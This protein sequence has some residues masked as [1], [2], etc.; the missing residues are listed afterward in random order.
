VIGYWKGI[1]TSEKQTFAFKVGLTSSKSAASRT[2]NATAMNS[3]VETGWDKSVSGGATAG[4]FGSG[5]NVQGSSADN[6][7]KSE[8]ASVQA[9]LAREI[10]NLAGESSEM[11]HETTCTP[12]DG[13]SGAG[14]W[15]WVLAT[16]DY[17]TS[18]FTSHTLCRTGEL[19]RTP[20]SCSFDECDDAQCT[21]CKSYKKFKTVD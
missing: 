3:A 12:G 21:V 5:V 18:A 1:T 19:A 8:G 16:S 6:G 11:S 17:S 15:Q 14:L 7:K 20:P 2:E 10:N 4:L 9:S 13:E